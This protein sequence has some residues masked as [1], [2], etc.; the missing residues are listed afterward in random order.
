MFGFFKK[1]KKNTDEFV[2]TT[3]I[4]KTPNQAK[5]EK[6]IEEQIKL[7]TDV[8]PICGNIDKDCSGIPLRVG[9]TNV[10]VIFSECTNSKCNAEW[11]TKYTKIWEK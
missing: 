9:D 8:C 7:K 4:T 2:I 3:V 11:E 6:E 1:K 10:Y 5:Y